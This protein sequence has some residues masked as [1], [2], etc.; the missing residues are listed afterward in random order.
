MICNII[1]VTLHFNGT[2][3][4]FSVNT[5]YKSGSNMWSVIECYRYFL[6]DRDLLFVRKFI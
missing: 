1:G 6:C 4:S 2:V 3:R 5:S